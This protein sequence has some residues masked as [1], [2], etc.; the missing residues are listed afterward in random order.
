MGRPWYARERG[1]YRNPSILKTFFNNVPFG[2][3]FFGGTAANPVVVG[4]NM[5]G[6]AANLHSISP[7][8]PHSRYD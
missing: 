7:A 3:T 5:S 8:D 6:T 1:S 4:S 2:A